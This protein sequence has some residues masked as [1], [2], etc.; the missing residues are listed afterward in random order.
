MSDILRYPSIT[1]PLSFRDAGKRMLRNAQNNTRSR[2][3]VTQLS[4][5]LYTFINILYIYIYITYKSALHNYI[6]ISCGSLSTWQRNPR[7]PQG[8]RQSQS[9]LGS[10]HASIRVFS[11]GQAEGRYLNSTSR[12]ARRV[13]TQ[14]NPPGEVMGGGQYHYGMWSI[15]SCLVFTFANS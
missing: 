10:R 1:L 3:R 2:Y 14:I 13:T 15:C 6:I 11:P 12:Q 8:E 9:T 7:N 5:Y 4:G